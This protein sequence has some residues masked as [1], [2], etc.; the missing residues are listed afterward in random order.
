[1]YKQVHLHFQNSQNYFHLFQ[2]NVYEPKI[3]QTKMINL[4][5]TVHI[6]S[7]AFLNTKAD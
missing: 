2:K 3:K 6:V 7:K 4:H 5:P 1:M